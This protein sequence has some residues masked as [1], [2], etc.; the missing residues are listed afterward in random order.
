MKIEQIYTGCI[1]HAAY[2]LESNG[3][4]AIFD[5]L[6]EVQ[7]YIDRAFKDNAKIKYVFL[8]HFHADFVSGH[9]DLA[10]K[11]N[12][13]IVYGPTAKPAYEIITAEDGQI[14][15]IGNYKVKVL[16]T[17]GHT[18]ESTTFLLIDENGKEHGLITGDTLFIGDVGR[19]DLAQHVVA[20][21]TQDKLAR[22]LY[23]SLRNKIMP[24]SDDLIVYPNHGAGSAC[25]KM[26]SKETTDTLGNQK[27][28][29]YALNPKMTED[30]FVTAV[31]TGLTAPPG[32]FPAN[33][34]M[35][36]NGYESLDVVLKKANTPL[37]VEEFELISNETRAL[38]LDTRLASEFADGFI[39]NSVNIG[40]DGNFAMWVGE[41]IPD[42]KQEILLVTETG[43]EEESMVRLS[44]I[45]YDSTIGYLKDGFESWKKAGKEV[46]TLTRITATE[47]EEKLKNEEIPVF[48]VRKK[49][50]YLSEHL[51]GAVNV[52]L[53][54][55][56]N[57]LAE[58]PKEKPFI[59]HC[60]G[61]YRSMLAASI[62]KMRGWD[63]FVDVIGGFTEIKE[64]SLPKTDYVCPT[65]LL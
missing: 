12:A 5:P 50:E 9:L 60:A 10:N 8:T 37:N 4:A 51:V 63:N 26:M 35:N 48:D 13:K 31:L 2:Y 55:I 52:P 41:M 16:H 43:K 30:E 47:L 49:S 17:P 11:T 3:E 54:E 32:Y 33:V 24:L 46:D 57:H 22:H 25:G 38:I 7:P 42:I 6:R 64:T 39:P 34:L 15:E 19:P 21:L 20:D 44:R 14:F 40:L 56:N 62:L 28:T 1:A 58:F 23:Q 29:N 27:K 61:G 59:L 53:N 65:T 36:I 18:M 45:G